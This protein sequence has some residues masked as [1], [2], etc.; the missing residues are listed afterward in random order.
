[1]GWTTTTTTTVIG[2]WARKSSTWGTRPDCARCSTNSRWRMPK[3]S[4]NA[5][6]RWSSTLALDLQWLHRQRQA[7][8]CHAQ[9][10][11]ALVLGVI[12]PVRWSRKIK[13]TVHRRR[14]GPGAQ[15]CRATCDGPRQDIDVI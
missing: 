15:T 9:I 3:M 1:M 14:D 7:K 11:L 6:T 10:E 2:N 12:N 4:K 8:H 5:P 13:T